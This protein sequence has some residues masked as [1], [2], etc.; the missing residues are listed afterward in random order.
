[1][2]QNWA[3]KVDESHLRSLVDKICARHEVSQQIEFSNKFL[4]LAKKHHQA[5]DR[6]I[7]SGLPPDLG[8]VQKHAKKLSVSLRNLNAESRQLLPDLFTDEFP[9]LSLTCDALASLISKMFES[10]SEIK[11]I[12][13]LTTKRFVKL[14]LDFS[15]PITWSKE[16]DCCPNASAYVLAAVFSAEKG[17]L[18]AEVSSANYYI[19]KLSKG[20]LCKIDGL[21]ARINFD[22]V[23]LEPD[24]FVFEMVSSVLEGRPPPLRT[25][26]NTIDRASV[27]EHDLSLGYPERKL[28]L[29]RFHRS[30]Q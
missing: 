29:R 24:P 26:A 7:R 19:G 27:H 6:L 13:E 21:V 14:C 25:K 1:M 5:I 9:T 3:D 28:G 4:S 30:P 15:I 20:F 16:I 12:K 18:A 11:A 17:D 2:M 23:T 8:E 22:Q 10:D